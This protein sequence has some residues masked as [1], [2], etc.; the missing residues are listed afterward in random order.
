[1]V[2]FHNQN[3]CSIMNQDS[4]RQGMELICRKNGI[5]PVALE[6]LAQAMTE[7]D[8][9]KY[10][11]LAPDR[12]Q[13]FRRGLN[14]RNEMA[15]PRASD[16]LGG[17][18]GGL[19]SGAIN[20][21]ANANEGLANAANYAGRA[22]AAP[23][24]IGY[25]AGKAGLQALGNTQ[26][27]Q[28]LQALGRPAL[29]AIGQGAQGLISAMPGPAAAGAAL[30]RGAVAAGGQPMN[31][32]GRPFDSNA[33]N[34][35]QLAVGAGPSQ[36][37]GQT[38]QGGTQQPGGMGSEGGG[39]GGW[40]GRRLGGAIRG[41]PG[42][43]LGML[44]G[45]IAGTENMNKLYGAAG[46]FLKNMWGGITGAPAQQQGQAPQGQM[47]GAQ[48]GGA[49]AAAPAAPQ[50]QPGF[51]PDRQALNKG[52]APAPTAVPSMA[53]QG[54]SQLV[55]SR[56]IAN[57]FN[58][59]AG[60]SG[61]MNA[62][63]LRA[64]TPRTTAVQQPQQ[65]TQP[66]GVQQPGGVQQPAGMQKQQA[67]RGEGGIV[68]RGHNAANPQLYSD[69]TSRGGRESGFHTDMAGNIIP[70][71]SKHASAYQEGAKRA[72]AIY[73]L[74]P[75]D[76]RGYA[77]AVY[78]KGPQTQ[79]HS[80]H[81][82]GFI[83]K[84]AEYGVDPDMLV[85]EASKYMKMFQAGKLGAKEIARLV[86]AK[87]LPETALKKIRLGGTPGQEAVM[88]RP[89]EAL[90]PGQ[91]HKFRGEVKGRTAAKETERAVERT[92]KQEAMKPM[93]KDIEPSIY[94][95]P[96]TK[97]P[98]PPATT[99]IP[100][101][102][103]GYGNLVGGKP[104]PLDP[105]LLE[106]LQLEGPSILGRL[107]TTAAKPYASIAGLFGGGEGLRTA[108]REAQDA[109]ARI[110]LRRSKFDRMAAGE[111]PMLNEAELAVERAAHEADLALIN[112]PS[113]RT[114]GGWTAGGLGAGGLLGGYAMLPGGKKDVQP[115]GLMRGPSAYEQ[116]YGMP[117]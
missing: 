72:C 27:G 2:L 12:R 25:E 64:P 71:G 94:G 63:G 1:M 80:S 84:C 81:S 87:L 4:Y 88:L 79:A 114:A 113:L 37:G 92:R 13:A 67:A 49:P 35:N 99:G 66:A 20:L 104:V 30:G 29:Q 45:A 32:Y 15:P 6:K 61:A 105:A 14:V 31:Q 8:L 97:A 75:D 38:P 68:F 55:A 24:Q 110:H 98:T 69:V 101:A 100:A 52:P 9:Q 85:K 102:T 62:A 7:A 48:P 34:I 73:G 57:P 103:E 58:P 78:A 65:P 3:G 108:G 96:K 76:I 46:G 107:G 23:A 83:A 106:R 21:G 26:T 60:A 95:G 59:L 22:I 47:M 117:R 5:E 56:M 43:A 16:V 44:G 93:P 11:T 39:F 115:E 36:G 28:E 42:G 77:E 17:Q 109:L 111:M 82:D 53:Q 54:R 50:G 40:L 116:Y 91:L 19:I 112:N 86:E 89:G 41:I 70:V 51:S 74:T 90:S 18:G 33:A 10:K